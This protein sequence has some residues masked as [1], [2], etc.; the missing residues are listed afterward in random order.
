M[1]K[2]TLT[3]IGIILAGVIVIAAFAAYTTTQLYTTQTESLLGYLESRIITRAVASE[4]SERVIYVNGMGVVYTTPDEAV[5]QVTVEASNTSAT[6][7]QEEATR[8]MASVIKAMK[9]LGIK[10]EHMKTSG[11]FLTPIRDEKT[12]LK[13]IGYIARN[14]LTITVQDL[15]KV[16]E[17]VEKAITSGA[18]I[19]N[20]LT[21]Q[22]SNEKAKAL[23]SEALTLAVQDAKTQA[24]VAAAAAGTK[25]IGLK[26]LT[27]GGIYLPTRTA[28]AAEA[29]AKDTYIMPGESQITVSVSA[30]F[31]IE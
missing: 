24:E 7:A 16:G 17:V 8:K 1:S 25:V 4:G 10:D 11:L 18:N 28:L 13:I 9:E 27:I 5:V 19:I 22:V 3:W 2:P 20:S 26:S 12:G 21:F 29:V 23:K 15:S 14:T 31:L 6:L 30:T